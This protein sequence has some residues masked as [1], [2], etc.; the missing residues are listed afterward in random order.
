MN[1][2]NLMKN[3]KAHT[4]PV[5]KTRF[6]STFDHVG[7]NHWRAQR[8]VCVDGCNKAVPMFVCM[9][10]VHHKDTADCALN[11]VYMSRSY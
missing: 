9:Q 3:T 10:Y 11:E 1:W 5:F 2:F 4:C 7:Q 8:S 6:S